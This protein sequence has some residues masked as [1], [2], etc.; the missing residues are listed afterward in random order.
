MEC[1]SRVLLLNPPFSCQFLMS[2]GESRVAVEKLL[3]GPC[4]TVEY[5]HRDNGRFCEREAEGEGVG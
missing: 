1:I 5:I 2:P 3:M 4:P